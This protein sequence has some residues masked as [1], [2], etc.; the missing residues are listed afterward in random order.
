MG[1]YVLGELGNLRRVKSMFT[2]SYVKFTDWKVK[3]T[4]YDIKVQRL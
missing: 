4:N 3:F 1:R 2:D